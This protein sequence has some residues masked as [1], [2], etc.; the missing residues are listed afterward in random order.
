MGL[1]S[2][3]GIVT[4]YGLGSPGTESQWGRDFSHPSRLALGPNKPPVQWVLGPSC[5]GKVAEAWS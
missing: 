4:C 5:G 1:D 2:S 3:V